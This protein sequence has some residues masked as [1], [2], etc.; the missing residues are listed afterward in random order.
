MSEGAIRS[1]FSDSGGSSGI[2]TARFILRTLQVEDAGATYLSWF[3]D[4]VVRRFIVAAGDTQSLQTLQAFIAEKRASPDAELFGIFVKDSGYHI[5]NFK[6]EPIDDASHRSIVGVLIGNPA[7][8]GVGVFREIYPRAARW[9]FDTRG[10][11]EFWLGIDADNAAAL[12]SYLRAGFS[13]AAPQS[14]LFGHT[15]SG[16]IYMTHRLEEE[17]PELQTSTPP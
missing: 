12:S 4:P 1:L 13:E 5:G 11:R 3:S 8:R 9:L 15:R 6:F 7:W 16:A 17:P 10:I 2:E 14:D